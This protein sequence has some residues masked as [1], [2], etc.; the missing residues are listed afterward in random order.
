MKKKT[1]IRTLAPTAAI[2]LMFSAS[3]SG[4]NREAGAQDKVAKA[5]PAPTLEE[6]RLT[7]GK[8]IETQQ[9]ISKERNEWQQG[10]EILVGR[11][12][13]V[14]KEFGG[15]DEKIKQAEAS[16][17]E[18][19]AKRSS[20]AAE[21][22][23]LEAVGVQ[24]TEAVTSLEREVRRLF[25][26]MPEPLQA[27]LQ[28]L[29]VRVPEDPAVTHASVAERF[30]NVLGILNELN[31]SNTEISVSYEVH[32][33]SDG[34]PAEVR[35]L[36]VGL[37]QAYFVSSGGDA[38]IGR[39]SEDGWKWEA[40]K[41]LAGEILTALEIIQGKHSPAFLPLPVTIQ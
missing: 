5:V 20:L 16:I 37:A 11:L 2:C 14:Q 27:R 38:G 21:K 23:R 10:K 33:L 24:L 12:D 7:M 17:A 4:D 41:P 18:S 22:E 26:Q 39:P 8:W 1:D 25:K 35:A 6:T 36:Y 31:K 9:I 19:G 29:Y 40:A 30:Q 13:L 34:K 3:L 15:L 28:P 32:N